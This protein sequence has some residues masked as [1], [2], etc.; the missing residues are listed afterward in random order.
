MT[1]QQK[2]TV[3]RAMVNELN[4]VRQAILATKLT[5]GHTANRDYKRFIDYYNELVPAYFEVDQTAR[6]LP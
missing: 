2:N 6:Q 1:K 5:Q 3:T 4:R